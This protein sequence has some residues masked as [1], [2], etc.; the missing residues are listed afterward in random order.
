M[1]SYSITYSDKQA[2][3][4]LNAVSFKAKKLKPAFES[5]GIFLVGSTQERFEK[6]VDPS[7]VPWVPNSPRTIAWKR[8]NGRINKIL[9]STGR[10][11]SSIFYKA[12]NNSV[13]ISANTPYAGNPQLGLGQPVREYLGISET[14]SSEVIAIISRYL[15]TQA[16]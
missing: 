5:V 2:L 13:T 3:R 9:Q 8:A 10:L 11:K 7:G 6:E 16:P 4:Q 12:T 14:D 15:S 1:S